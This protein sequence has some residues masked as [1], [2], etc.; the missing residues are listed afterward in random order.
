MIEEKIKSLIKI[1]EE[2]TIDEIEI[3]TL[4]GKQKIRVKKN[5]NNYVSEDNPIKSISK[6]P[7][8]NESKL[9]NNKDKNSNSSEEIKNKNSINE[10]E[11]KYIKAP[12]VGTFYQSSKPGD[13][14]FI[15]KGDKIKE[16]QIIC[17][18][19]AMKIFNEIESDISGTVVEI[20][21]SDASPIEYDQNL[22]EI[23]PD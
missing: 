17:I 2:S 14:P 21:V 1:L 19:E 9:N 4:W 23:I 16:G 11:K 5:S 6:N 3:S 20:L 8:I 13:P 22:I 7:T 18:I 12:L 15:S 10:I